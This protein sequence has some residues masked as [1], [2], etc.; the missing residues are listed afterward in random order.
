MARRPLPRI[1]S[2]GGAQLARSRE[3][4]RTAADS[5]TDILHPLITVAR[6]LG[7]LAAAGRRRWAETPKD[8]RGPLLFVV[9]AL[10]LTVVVLPYGPLL[11]A[12][13]VTAAAAWQGRDRA[14]A[15]PA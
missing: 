10:C 3:L 5:A 12:V 7:R 14:P 4:A 6:G 1:L 2:T 11:A 13:A 15:E 8:R 9:A